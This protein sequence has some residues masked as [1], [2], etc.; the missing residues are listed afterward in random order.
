MDEAWEPLFASLVERRR[1]AI[2]WELK[3]TGLGLIALFAV[4]TLLPLMTL[5]APQVGFR[6]RFAIPWA[7]IVLATGSVMYLRARSS[8]RAL[9]DEKLLYT[10]TV[11]EYDKHMAEIDQLKQEVAK[12]S[13][14][15]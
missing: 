15:R 9:R 6:V 12:I 3:W 1:A 4:G 13:R 11:A 7:M 8:L 5:A 14:R 10:V 2:P